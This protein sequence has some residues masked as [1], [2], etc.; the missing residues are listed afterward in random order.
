M[1]AKYYGTLTYLEAVV[2]N[3]RV[4][5]ALLNRVLIAWIAL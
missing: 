1:A 5:A 3:G 2:I 4:M